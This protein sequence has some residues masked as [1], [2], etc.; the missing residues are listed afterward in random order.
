MEIRK[1]KRNRSDSKTPNTS[2]SLRVKHHRNCGGHKV[3]AVEPIAFM[4]TFVLAVTDW[5]T[6]DSL[7]PDWLT[8]LSPSCYL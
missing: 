2:C 4:S 7:A 5:F 8:A 6:A 3:P 1:L